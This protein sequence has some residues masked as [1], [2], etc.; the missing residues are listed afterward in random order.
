MADDKIHR[1]KVV[2]TCSGCS[3][4]VSRVLSKT[5]GVNQFDVSLEKQEVTVRTTGL[6]QDA[7]FEVIKKT[8]KPVE[9]LPSQ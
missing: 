9:A 6:T 1:F 5:P 8:G 4:A 3:N 7:V 2:M